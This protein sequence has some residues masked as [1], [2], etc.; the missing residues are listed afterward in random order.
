MAMNYLLFI[1]KIQ[2]IDNSL[3]SS[4]NAPQIRIGLNQQRFSE[5]IMTIYGKYS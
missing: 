4:N 5:D 2:K 1:K 3:K